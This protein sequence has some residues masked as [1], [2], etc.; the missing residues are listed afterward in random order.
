SDRYDGARAFTADLKRYL[1]G[2]LV[3]SHR[4]SASEIVLRWLRRHRL[5]AAIGAAAVVALA[6]TGLLSLRRI[7]AEKD[8][9]ERQRAAAEELSQFMLEDLT[10]QLQPLGRLEVLDGVG[11]KVEGYYRT[12]DSVSGADAASARRR[13]QAL[14]IIG[15]VEL[16]RGKLESAVDAF[17]RSE[18][19]SG[20]LAEHAKT[21]ARRVAALLDLG[22]VDEAAAA[23]DKEIELVRAAL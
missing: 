23:T 3:S 18:S 10:R 15:R 9:A 2:Q 1:T 16:E 17:R 20:P 21:V 14:T 11:K 5:P 8:R 22:R 13:A 7:V 6:A 4:Y 19:I 12:L